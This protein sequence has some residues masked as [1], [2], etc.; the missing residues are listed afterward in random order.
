MERVFITGADRGI[1][2]ALARE[3]L[4]HGYQV[5]AGQYMPDWPELDRL[6]E[7]YPDTL[8]VIPLDVGN[9]DSVKKACE[10]IKEQTD[11]ID[12]LVNVAGISGT[13][14]REKLQQLYEVNAVGAI[15]VVDIF[16][17]LMKKGRRKICFFSSEAGSIALSDRNDMDGWLG[18]SSSK[19]MLNMAIRLMFNKL[20][21]QGYQFRVYHPGGVNGYMSGKKGTTS[22][23]EPEETARVAFRQFVTKRFY[24]D[25]LLLTDV[26]DMIWAF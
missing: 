12:I 24:E 10:K 16:L 20:N 1:G 9:T 2:Q 4:L 6:K 14:D 5:Y 21:A 25:V 18:Y 15:R 17:P 7:K 23:Y 22:D 3:F 26:E 13:M 19:A 11:Y 8:A